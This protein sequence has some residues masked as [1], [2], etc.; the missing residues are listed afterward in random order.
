MFLQ[1]F[2]ALRASD[3]EAP[4]IHNVARISSTFWVSLIGSAALATC[5]L[6]TVEADSEQTGRSALVAPFFA[7]SF[8]QRSFRPTGAARYSRGFSI[9]FRSRTTGL[10]RVTF[11]TRSFSAA[12]PISS[13]LWLP[14]SPFLLPVP[15]ESP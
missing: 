14:L 10:H 2:A 7:T 13:S 9:C 5:G 1:N 4:E 3:A 15:G 8:L 11:A 12:L 6:A